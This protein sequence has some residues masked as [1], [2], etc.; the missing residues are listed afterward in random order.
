MAERGDY[1]VFVPGASE[2]ETVEAYIKN[3]S[4]DLAFARLVS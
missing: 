2:G 3:V 1:T 4:G